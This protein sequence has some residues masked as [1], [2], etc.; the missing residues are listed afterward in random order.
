MLQFNAHE[1]YE[2]LRTKKDSL[3]PSKSTVIGLAVYPAVS[4]FNH[5]CHGGVARYFVGKRMVI[6]AIK[7]VKVGEEVHENY[8]PAFYFKG[9]KER[10]HY[11]KSRFVV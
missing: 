5:S 4:Y 1:V 2:V 7:S 9:R 10:Q 6:K 8:G 3:F 11:L